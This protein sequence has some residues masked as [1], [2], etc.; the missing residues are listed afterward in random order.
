MT[1]KGK[2]Y[3]LGLFGASFNPLHLGH[4]NLL[5]QVQEKFNFDLIKVIPAWQSP[6]SPPVQGEILPQKRLALVRKVFKDYPFVEV[7]DQEIK[8]K[9]ISYTTDTMERIQKES[10]S[11]ED[12]FLIMGID[13][14]AQFDRWKNFNNLLEK[15][16]L[17]VCSRKGYEW[18]MS[19]IPPA[20]RQCIPAFSVQ[21][22]K[23]KTD[24]G[25]IADTD[26]QKIKNKIPLTTGKNIYWIALNDMDISSSQI[27]KRCKKGLSVAH[28]VPPVV[29]QWIQKQ[30]SYQS[31]S[32]LQKASGISSLVQFCAR[33][34]LSK[35]AHKV[36]CFDLR[37]FSALPFDFTLVASGLN[38]RHTK[39]MAGHLH[40]Q[41]KKEFSFFAQYVEGQ[42]KG[43]WIVL[44][45][46]WLAV[47][48][49]YDYTREHYRLEDLWEKA[50]VQ[51]FVSN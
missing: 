23:N 24:C 16:H 40:R 17:L 36:K 7:D 2:K 13:Q 26:I 3:K 37:E 10:S 35:K 47:H 50:P 51:N 22:N 33:V 28:L 12:I 25:L 38:T 14:L 8:R 15:T 1:K 20:L 39:M 42:E 43:E 18:S 41:V 32:S 30:Q 31:H 34:V 46:G 27:R 21:S 9:G 48:I 49:F 5:V 11:S 6:L 4:L 45:Y 29:D 19:V 44:D